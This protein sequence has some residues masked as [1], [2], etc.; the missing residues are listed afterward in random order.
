M[1]RRKPK[2]YEPIKFDPDSTFDGPLFV[3]HLPA[4][5]KAVVAAS[6]GGGKYEAMQ[7][8]PQ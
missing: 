1:N 2:L 8:G 4:M 3:L 7:S 5:N 6:T